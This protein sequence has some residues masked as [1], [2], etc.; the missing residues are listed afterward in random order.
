M[1]EADG[2][3]QPLS[4][5]SPPVP[6]QLKRDLDIW[7]SENKVARWSAPEH[8]GVVINGQGEELGSELHDGVFYF[9]S[10]RHGGRG[11]LDI[12]SARL[13][14]TGIDM[15]EPLSAPINSC[16]SE[17][18]YSLCAH[19]VSIAANRCRPGLAYR[20]ARF[21]GPNLFFAIGRTIAARE[22]HHN[23][24]PPARSLVRDA[25]H[26]CPHIRDF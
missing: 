25:V 16:A 23:F 26:A 14:A 24:L 8:F 7:R 19:A 21:R 3:V 15:P 9:A 5:L 6:D 4:H 12:D 11:D 13:T 20:R 22:Q 17:G 18:D 10:L 2:F 1:R